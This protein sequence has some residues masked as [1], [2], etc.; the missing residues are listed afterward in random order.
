MAVMRAHLIIS[1]AVQGVNFRWFV[2][3][4][5]KEAGVNGYVKNLE[6]G[7]VEVICESESEKGYTTLVHKLESAK[8]QKGLERIEVKGIKVLSLE[9]NAEPKYNY[10]NIEY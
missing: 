10:F 8:E 7:T 4:N 6:D 9:K 5:A 3:K 2:Q 1:G